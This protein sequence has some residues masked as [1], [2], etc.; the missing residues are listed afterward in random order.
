MSHDGLPKPFLGHFVAYVK[1][2]SEPRMYPTHFYVFEEATSPQV[3]LSYV[4]SERLGIVAFK[5]SN[6]AATSQVDNLNVP[7]SPRPSSSRKTTKTVTFW[8]PV[9]EATVLHCSTPATAAWGRPLPQRWVIVLCIPQ[10]HS[11][12]PATHIKSALVHH[13]CPKTTG[14]M[15][16][17]FKAQS[18]P[19]TSPYSTAQVQDIMALKRAF[20][21][22]FDTTGN[23]S[24]MYTIRTDPNTLPIQNALHKVP[25]EYQ[26]QIKNTLDGMV[27]NGVIMP[28]SWPTEWVS[29]I[30]YPH[31][32][33]G[34]LHICLDPNNLNKAIMREHYKAPNL[35]EISHHLSGAT[36][37]SK[38]DAK[39]GFWSICLDEK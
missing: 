8:D 16:S 35:D 26:E 3:L 34:S 38:V 6:L 1:H 20:P 21:N 23:M 37:F 22:S 19:A 36:C 2:A 39:D 29:L 32:P 18:P 14:P 17:A 27:T 24:G 15:K 31:K 11:A 12:Y 28:V 25:I 4:T 30:M 13:L 5:V 7:T 33:D 9:V 10:A